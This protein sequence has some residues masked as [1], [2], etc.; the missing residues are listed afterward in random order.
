MPILTFGLALAVVLL[1]SLTWIGPVTVAAIVTLAGWAFFRDFERN[2]PTEP[3]ILISPADGTVTDICEIDEPDFFQGPVLRIGI[4]LS[5]FSV[6]V[7]RAPCSGK[8]SYIKEKPG[9]CLNAMR[10]KDASEQN[11]STCLGLDC[12]DHPAQKVMV[13]QIT[14]AIARRIVCATQI[15]EQLTSAQRYGMIK[16]GSRTELYI[17]RN[18]DA[19]I[20]VKKGDAVRGGL[21]RLVRYPQTEHAEG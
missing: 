7:N 21:T 19:N 17:P 2:S 1:T 5:V 18:S 16:F 15:G 6:H 14:G 13:K 4:F 3:N 8:V 12:P 11:Q 20:L 10:S 9:K